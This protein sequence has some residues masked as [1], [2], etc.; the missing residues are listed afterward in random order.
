MLP[1]QY[2]VKVIDGK[3]KI[4]VPK[5]PMCNG[6][7]R[8]Y[9]GFLTYESFVCVKCGFNIEDIQIEKGENHV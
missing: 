1:S 5:C 3:V 9:Q 4:I 2:E 7:W 8:Y 6:N